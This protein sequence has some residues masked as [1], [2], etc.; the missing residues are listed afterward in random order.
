[1]AD[2][3]RPCIYLLS[4]F[5]LKYNRCSLHC[6]FIPS[7]VIYHKIWNWILFAIYSFAISTNE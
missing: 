4:V 5:M 7:I 2:P 3:V 6:S 1:M